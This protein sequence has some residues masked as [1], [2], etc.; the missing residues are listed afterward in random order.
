MCIKCFEIHKTYKKEC[1]GLKFTCFNERKNIVFFF[2]FGYAV[3]KLQ[4]VFIINYGVFR[5]LL[6]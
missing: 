5:C 1:L 4:V 6:Q 2:T 3:H